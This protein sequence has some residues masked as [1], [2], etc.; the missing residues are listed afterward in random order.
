MTK[1]IFAISY[2]LNT[3]FYP[4]PAVAKNLQLWEEMKKA[5]DSGVRC[6]VRAKIDMTSANGCMRDPTIYRCKP[7][8]HP[9]TGSQYK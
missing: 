5:S 9:R 4:N 1:F 3:L 2:T 6:C 7:E 8:V